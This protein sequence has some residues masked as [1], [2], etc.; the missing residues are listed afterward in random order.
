MFRVDAYEARSVTERKARE[1]SVPPLDTLRRALAWRRR[2]GRLWIRVDEGFGRSVDAFKWACDEVSAV[3]GEEECLAQTGIARVGNNR[4]VREELEPS[5]EAM[6]QREVSRKKI[7]RTT[8]AYG[9]A[10]TIAEVVLR[11]ARNIHAM[12]APLI[13]PRRLRATGDRK[14]GVFCSKGACTNRV[15]HPP[16]CRGLASRGPSFE[17]LASM[18]RGAS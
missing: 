1:A 18:L 13:R 4:P 10:Q 2:Q 15:A 7:P 9:N 17:R 14:G 11:I 5:A 6:L 16:D 8:V 3:G 12:S